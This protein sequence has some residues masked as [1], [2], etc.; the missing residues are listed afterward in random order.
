MLR[1]AHATRICGTVR[2]VLGYA[3]PSRARSH[4]TAASDATAPT[5]A[6]ID[7]IVAWLQKD[8]LPAVTETEEPSSY[9]EKETEPIQHLTNSQ[10]TDSS[11]HEK[12]GTEH[13]VP[14]ASSESVSTAGAAGAPATAPLGALAA[15]VNTTCPGFVRGDPKASLVPRTADALRP[16]AHAE[17]V[18]RV[19]VRLTNR[20]T[21]RSILDWT[22]DDYVQAAKSIQTWDRRFLISVYSGLI[23]HTRIHGILMRQR[24]YPEVL[25]VLDKVVTKTPASVQYS[26]IAALEQIFSLQRIVELPQSPPA[27]YLEQRRK[28]AERKRAAMGTV[29][30]RPRRLWT[31]EENRLLLRIFRSIGPDWNK[32]AAALPGRSPYACRDRLHRLLGSK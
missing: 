14:A 21:F 22:L 28:C 7:D 24:K 9:I 12:A 11:A 4:V 8:L 17:E 23:P 6:A 25:K 16:I 19:N 27:E 15:L 1:R 5:E 30:A 13:P 31:V 26:W 3:V 20:K 32:I 29:P 10:A 2:A 18:I